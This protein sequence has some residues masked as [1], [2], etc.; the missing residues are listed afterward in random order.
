MK[1]WEKKE[2]TTRLHRRYDAKYMQQKKRYFESH[3]IAEWKRL[4]PKNELPEDGRDM[5]VYVWVY[6]L[7]ALH[8][9]Q[10]AEQENRY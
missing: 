10:K 2:T 5:Q 1:K 8:K 7:P 9:L 3:T 4:L 6:G